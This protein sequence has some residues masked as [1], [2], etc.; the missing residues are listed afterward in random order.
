MHGI[1]CRLQLSSSQ[2]PFVACGLIAGTHEQLQ[3]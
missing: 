3:V 1:D 2:L